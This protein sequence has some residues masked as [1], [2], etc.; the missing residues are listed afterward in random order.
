MGIVIRSP[1]DMFKEA[2]KR[3]H[4]RFWD[5]ERERS[6]HAALLHNQGPSVRS[7]FCPLRHQTIAW[8]GP[9]HDTIRAYICL[10][11]H[12]AACEPEI[13]D[14]GFDFETVPDW[15]I[16]AIFDLDLERQVA[17]SRSFFLAGRR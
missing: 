17:Q 16:K 11:C 7:R 6:N 14:R 3:L 9:P 15:E 5:K 2:E 13:K 1:V 10:D 12:A 4:Y 8:S